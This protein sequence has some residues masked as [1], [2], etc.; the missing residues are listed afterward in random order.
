ME[1]QPYFDDAALRHAASQTAESLLASLPAPSSCQHTFS[2]LFL[3]KIDVLLQKRRRRV[4]AQRMWQRVAVV[5][6]VVFLSAATWLSVDVQAREKLFQ[7]TKEVVDNI[8]VHHVDGGNIEAAFSGYEPT[9]L[10]EGFVLADRDHSDEFGFD[11]YYYENAKTGQVFYIN[12]N[13]MKD[14]AM[15]ITQHGTEEPTIHDIN[16]NQGKFYLPDEI[17]G[18]SSLV[19][20]DENAA[21]VFIIEGNISEQ[22]MLHIAKG[23]IPSNLTK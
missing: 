19:W 20:V 11:Y 1:K 9:W 2:E 12:C 17:S 8:I 5:F 10:P 14:S 21:V 16:G 3:K 22:E 18:S 7:W 6:L 13:F 15:T 23:I 4:A